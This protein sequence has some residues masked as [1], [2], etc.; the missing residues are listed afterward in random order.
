MKVVKKTGLVPVHTENSNDVFGLPPAEALRGLAAG[1]LFLVEIP[2]G[3]ET[4][5]IDDKPAAVK[6]EEKP[7]EDED[8]VI[9]GN[10]ESLHYT[11]IVVLAKQILGVED[12]PEDGDK[13]MATIAKEIVT[14]EIAKREADAAAGG[15]GSEGGEE[16]PAGTPNPGQPGS[17]D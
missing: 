11:K 4:Y 14:A 7:A 12:L 17:F 15:E 13:N 3:I 1:K 2:E 16:S 5:E 9:P 10:W 6:Q 8:V